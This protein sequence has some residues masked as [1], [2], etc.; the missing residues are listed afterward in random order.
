MRFEDYLSFTELNEYSKVQKAISL[1]NDLIRSLD[2]ME[3]F[4]EIEFNYHPE[5]LAEWVRSA[6]SD[7]E[8]SV[9]NFRETITQKSDES[10]ED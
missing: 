4:S 8:D 1:C 3:G 9:F 2:E 10:N 5:Q 7:L 6:K